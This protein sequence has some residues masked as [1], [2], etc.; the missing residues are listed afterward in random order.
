MYLTEEQPRGPVSQIVKHPLAAAAAAAAAAA[1]TTITTK[2]IIPV[3]L[4]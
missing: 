2:I 1:I 3:F 4:R